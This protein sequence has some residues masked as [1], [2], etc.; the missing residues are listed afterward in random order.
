MIN[1]FWIDYFKTYGITLKH[2]ERL[3][4]VAWMIVGWFWNHYSRMILHDSGNLSCH[5][6]VPVFALKNQ[7]CHRI[8]LQ[9]TMGTHVGFLSFCWFVLHFFTFLSSLWNSLHFLSYLYTS[10]MFE[11]FL[12]ISLHFFAFRCISFVPLYFFAF[13]VVSFILSCT[14]AIACSLANFA[15]VPPLCPP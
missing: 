13:L 12:S 3:L 6:G 15:Q 8:E 5:P 2:F 11:S 7:G 10:F 9:K 4:D 14:P 1:S